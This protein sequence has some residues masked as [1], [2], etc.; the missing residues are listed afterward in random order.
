MLRCQYCNAVI[1]RMRSIMF[2]LIQMSVC[3]LALLAIHHVTVLPQLIIDNS[4][5]NY[6]Y[7][8]AGDKIADFTVMIHGVTGTVYDYRPNDGLQTRIV[9]I[10]MDAFPYII[11]YIMLLLAYMIAYYCLVYPRVPRLRP[12]QAG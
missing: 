9:K 10:A 6:R 4:P 8:L 11:I 2:Y 7:T 12:R 1:A 5:I 3:A